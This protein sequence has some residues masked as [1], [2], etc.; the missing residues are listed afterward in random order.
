[1]QGWVRSRATVILI[2]IKVLLAATTIFFA[3]PAL[4]ADAEKVLRYAFPVAE[5]GFDP[6]AVSDRYSN[7]VIENIL[8]PMLAYDYLARPSKL[9]ANT[10]EAMPEVR[11][12][13][14]TYICRLKKGIYF[15]DDPAFQGRKRELTAHDYV[16][17]LR[18]LYDPKLRSPWLFLI[19]GKIV[20]AD[21]SMALAK[22]TGK[23]D[24][25]APIAGLQALDRYTLRIRLK[26]PDYNLLYILAMPSTSAL[27]REVVERYGDD[28]AAH[29][30][31]TGPFVLKQW[32][33]SSKIVLEANADYREEYFTGSTEDTPADRA[34]VA[35]L[36]G[37]KL[38][39]IGRVE[40]DIIEEPQP[41]W[42]A[43]INQEHDTLEGLPNEFV[44][45]AVPGG[46][47]APNLA[48]QNIQIERESQLDLTF[49]FYNMDNPVIGGY[50]AEK[51][52]LRRALNL[53]YNNNEE[54][55]LVRKGQ[56]VQ[57]QGLV[58]PGAAGYD[59]NFRTETGQY[60][61]AKAKALLDLF[62]YTDRDGDGW[63]EMPDGSPL[64]LEIAS[65][66]GGAS[67]PLDEL[68]K[69]ALDG[70][71]I[72]STF[73]KERWPDLVKLGKAGKVQ[74]GNYLSWG[75]DYPDGDNFLQLLYG[76]NAGQS[77]EARFKLAA[78]DR[79]YDEAKKLPDSPRRTQLYQEMTKLVLVYSPWK[80][81][82]HRVATSMHHPWVKG[83]KQ[84]PITRAVWKYLDIDV[85]AQRQ[86]RQ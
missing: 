83:R 59:A 21:E 8:E 43:F 12:G 55:F 79:L 84:H 3:P 75:A 5:T 14:T 17:S 19:E 15:T 80:L 45:I 29:P 71:G 42:L 33:R 10:L 56:A 24:Y 6:V 41:L 60:S 39:L 4:P 78:F 35:G 16:Y 48:K 61:P 30:V 11:D 62:H 1:M 58:P 46:K 51:V 25:E 20:G 22:K 47:L 50:T 54:I 70:I 63:R 34:I 66:P 81:G 32:R 64:M 31:G 76:P 49:T 67:R 73:K 85:A 36:Q 13:G 27:A 23:Y 44:N 77:N 26:E 68:W 69:K 40:V 72:R 2:T 65:P 86:A 52:A 57:A 82:T 38:P 7:I 28:I 37:K 53:A 18:R 9:V 74:I